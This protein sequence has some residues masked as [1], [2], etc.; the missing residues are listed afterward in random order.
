MTF[1]GLGLGFI[2]LFISILFFVLKLIF[3]DSFYLGMAPMLIGGFFVASIQFFFLGILGEYIGV[4]LTHVRTM[5]LVIERERI[6]FTE[7]QS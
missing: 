7:K 6:N 4:I 3:W 2:T 1:L 5:P